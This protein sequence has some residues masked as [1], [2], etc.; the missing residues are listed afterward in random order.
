MS[1]EVRDAQLE[2]VT[3]GPLERLDGAVTLHEHDPRWEAQ[4]RRE[5]ERISTALC[6]RVV[7]LEH[8]GST[9]VPGLVAKPRIDMLL[10]VA[11]SGDEPAYV[12][13]L[14]DVGY[15]LRI[16]EPDWYQHR[17]LNGPDFD[18]NLHVFSRGCPEIERMLRFRN[19]LRTNRADRERYAA[20]KRELAARRWRH[21][22]DYADA[23]TSIIEEILRRA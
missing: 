14:E 13:A 4:F 22:Q 11:D 16:R 1:D 18:V 12:L 2:A 3:L 9:S 5:A 7:E 19:R 17:L 21:T 8:V 20:V 6:G 10:V 15:R 23:K